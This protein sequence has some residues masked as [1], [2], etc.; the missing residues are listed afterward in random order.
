MLS[1][2][3]HCYFRK[4]EDPLFRSENKLLDNRVIV[5]LLEMFSFRHGMCCFRLNRTCFIFVDDEDSSRLSARM[6][7]SVMKT[8]TIFLQSGHQQ[9]LLMASP[10]FIKTWHVIA[11]KNFKQDS[12]PLLNPV[13]LPYLQM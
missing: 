12:D 7:T 8:L 9:T 6:W 11:G 10:V 5:K 1:G 2:H 13:F 4:S 3:V